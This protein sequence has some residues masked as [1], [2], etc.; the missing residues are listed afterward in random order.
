MINYN[1]NAKEFKNL[2]DRYKKVT[3]ISHKRPDGDTI[4]S[5]LALYNSLK[6]QNIKSE[7]VC[8][9]SIPIKYN[10]L[11]GFN[12][13]KKNISYSDSLIVTLDCAEKKRCG[14]EFEDN[15]KVIN[16]DHHSSN[17][18]F[19][20]LNIV[21]VEVST[22]AVLY[23]L[24]KEGFCINKDVA[25]ALYTGLI[26]DSQN[27]TTTLTNKNSFKIASELL[28]Y[29][30]NLQLVTNRVNRFNSLSHIRILGRAIN[31]LEL[32]NNAKV[33]IMEITQNDIKATDANF[34]DIDGIIDIAISLATVDVA[35]LIIEYEKFIKVSLRSKTKNVSTLASKFGGG[36]HKNASGF[37]INTTKIVE[38]KNKLINELRNI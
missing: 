37:E 35:I 24:L 36:G 28:D 3:I 27:F 38:I 12:R 8:I 19:G 20:D 30:V 10:F 26:S 1:H 25:T 5:A 14:F 2:L 34:S 6:C 32:Y 9:D 31:S 13:F 15:R 18:L 33:A 7:L 16:I 4:S 29:G 17:N 22:T 23:K 11:N 21:E